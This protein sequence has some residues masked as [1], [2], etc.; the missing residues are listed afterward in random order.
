MSEWNRDPRKC[1]R[2]DCDRVFVPSDPRGVFCS[3]HHWDAI[4]EMLKAMQAGED[5][6]TAV[7]RV[8]GPE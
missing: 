7:K 1:K 5:P 2:P 4:G 6:D 8:L 3:Q